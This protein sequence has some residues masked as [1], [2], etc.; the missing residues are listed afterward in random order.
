MFTRFRKND[1]NLPRGKLQNG[2]GHAY[3]NPNQQA[4]SCDVYVGMYSA[5]GPLDY[6]RM[7]KKESFFLR[8]SRFMCPEIFSSFVFFDFQLVGTNL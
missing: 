4:L 2:S 8:L 1:S 3:A 5:H 7:I 6:S